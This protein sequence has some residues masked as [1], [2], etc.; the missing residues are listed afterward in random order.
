MELSQETKGTS[1][2]PED[3]PSLELTSVISEPPRATEPWSG[4]SLHSMQLL[5]PYFSPLKLPL[6]SA[7]QMHSKI[8][9]NMKIKTPS[10]HKHPTNFSWNQ[11]KTELHSA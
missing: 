10:N 6:L 7:N 1:G 5:T 8:Q 9:F 11:I 4:E 3:S 2:I